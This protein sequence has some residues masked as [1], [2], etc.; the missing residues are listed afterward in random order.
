MDDLGGFFEGTDGELVLARAPGRLDLLG[1]I[2]DYSGSLV[3]ELPLAESAHVAAARSREDLVRVVSRGEQPREVV[4]P[5]GELW[6]A[7]RGLGE[8]RAYFEGLP[9]HERWVAYVLGGLPLL[10]AERGLRLEGGLRVLLASEVPEGK[11]VSSSAAIEVAA[12]A[13][14]AELWGAPMS[15]LELG[16]ACQRVENL[17]V[18]APCGVMDQLTA[19]CAEEGRL[20]AILCQP[21][22][23]Q[24][25]LEVPDDLAVLGIDSGVRHAVGSG[26]YGRVRAAAFMGLRILAERLG[27]RVVPLA[28]GRVALEDDPLAYLANLGPERLTPELVDA[29]PERMSGAEFLA[30]YAGISDALTSVEAASQYM[31]R[32]ATLHPIFEHERVRSFVAGLAGARDDGSRSELGQLLFASHESY[33]ACGLGSPATDR[34]VELARRAGPAAGVFGAKITGG[35]GGGAV[36]VLARRDALSSVHAIARQYGDETGRAAQVFAR[37]SPGALSTP[38]VRRKL[39][40]H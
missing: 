18:G 20:L 21:A 23:L 5:A 15:G 27:A 17:V 14:L 38:P 19:A 32:A 39:V 37:S 13:A 28:P 36:V 11:G 4:L 24:G 33:S 7:C 2:A 25:C 22:Q 1:G 10:R 8:A 26:H 9:A 16:L 12:L 3:L 40:R 34:L 30:R 29:L 6:R 31:V 35:G